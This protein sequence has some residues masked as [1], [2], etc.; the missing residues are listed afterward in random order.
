MRRLIIVLT[1]LSA[2]TACGIVPT[3]SLPTPDATA[4]VTPQGSAS[5]TS[6]ATSLP[7]PSPS[8]VRSSVFAIVSGPGNV[9]KLMASD[10]AVLASADAAPAPY[11][12]NFLMPWTSATRTRVYFLAGGSEVRYMAPDGTSGT[13]AR[14]TLTANQQAGISVSPDDKKIAVAI[15]S[16]TPNGDQTVSNPPTYDG[17]R[18]YVEDLAGGGHHRDIFAST[19]VAEFPIGWI[20]GQLLVA[21]GSPVCCQTLQI[22]PYGATSYHVV[23]AGTGE[24]LVDL[25]ANTTGPVGPVEPIGIACWRN[26]FAPI[27]RRWDGSSFPAPTAIPSPFQYLVAMA[28]D[29]TKVAIG[30]DHIR[31]MSG[32]L[33]EVLTIG[34]FAY[35]WLDSYH[36]VYAPVG[37]TIT[38]FD[39]MSRTSVDLASSYTYLGTFP[40]AIS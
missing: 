13:V 27:F 19:Q 6:S 39:F 8:P 16:Y 35:G 3:A 24:R 31:I 7:R 28:P 9:V 21:V 32:G 29:G 15:L 11:R 40:A 1:L 5:P 34:G 17:M 22:N 33:D 30:G 14:I 18:L 25:C 10:G 26:G 20:S 38:V 2:C 37:G 12:Q 4:D 23:D 36:L